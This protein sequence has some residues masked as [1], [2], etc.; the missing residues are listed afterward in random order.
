MVTLTWDIS[1]CSRA[2]YD[3]FLVYSF[4][5]HRWIVSMAG[6]IRCAISRLAVS[7]APRPRGCLVELAGEPGPIAA[8]RMDLARQPILAAIALRAA[9]GRASSASSASAS[10][11]LGRWIDGIRC[12]LIGHPPPLRAS[13]HAKLRDGK[14]LS[15]RSLRRSR[16]SVNAGGATCA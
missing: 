11:L 10:R 12:L 7:S 9:L 13:K 14:H 8:E 4:L 1:F 6:S 2:L 15:Q 5:Q 16:E 3:R